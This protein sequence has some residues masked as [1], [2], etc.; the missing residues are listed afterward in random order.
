M[1]FLIILILNFIDF[2]IEFLNHKIINPH[3]D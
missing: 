3:T 2:K 1:I